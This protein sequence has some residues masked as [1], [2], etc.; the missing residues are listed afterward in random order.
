MHFVQGSFSM[1]SRKCGSVSAPFYTNFDRV[2]A[3][4]DE[5]GR[6]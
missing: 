3:T 2:E 5:S 6:N 1:V 4:R